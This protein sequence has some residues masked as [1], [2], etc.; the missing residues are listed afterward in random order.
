MDIL[1]NPLQ[2]EMLVEDACVD[3]AFAVDFIGGDKSEGSELGFDQS[4]DLEM[5]PVELTRY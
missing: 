4:M 3:C 2:S 5:D 1:L